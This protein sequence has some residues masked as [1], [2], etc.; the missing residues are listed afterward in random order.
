MFVEIAEVQ[1]REGVQEKRNQRR[2]T[3]ENTICKENVRHGFLDVNH[4]QDG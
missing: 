4:P 2:E 1:E 3:Q